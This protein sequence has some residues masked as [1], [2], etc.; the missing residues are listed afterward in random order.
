MKHKKDT[1]IQHSQSAGIYLLQEYWLP[2]LI[3]IVL[4]L[5]PIIL[6]IFLN[7]P[8]FDKVVGSNDGW[9]GFWGGYLGAIFA[10][11]GVYLQIEKEKKIALR[12]SR[13]VFA[14]LYDQTVPQSIDL[15]IKS[16]VSQEFYIDNVKR[17]SG[18]KDKFG[19]LLDLGYPIKIE[20]PSTNPML[21]VNITVKYKDTFNNHSD[22][23]CFSISR[24][25]AGEIVQCI[26]F[27]YGY[28]G[29]KITNKN[30]NELN[31]FTPI[32][33]T[34]DIEF[35]TSKGERMF[36]HYLGRDDGKTMTRIGKPKVRRDYYINQFE[37]SKLVR[38]NVN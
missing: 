16:F 1:E 11:S 17:V 6:A 10:V 34:L 26:P 28:E 32:V 21:F 29:R 9:L 18:E 37:E 3:L 15:K 35:T 14:I 22:K 20:N 7:T 19:N 27:I 23:E 8:F 13:P 31:K 2:L 33:K 5:I 24:I 12:N 4:I 38:E 30:G 36:Y 25:N